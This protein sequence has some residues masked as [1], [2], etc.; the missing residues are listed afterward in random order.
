MANVKSNSNVLAKGGTQ[1]E[2][3]SLRDQGQ[4]PGPAA[5]C[6]LEPEH[7]VLDAAGPEVS[8]SKP[9]AAGQVGG[10][11]TQPRGVTPSK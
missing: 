3:P 9:R 10:N 11:I 7:G 2:S 6:K 4:Q 8:S 5:S 1:Q